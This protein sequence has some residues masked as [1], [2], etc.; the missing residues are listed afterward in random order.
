MY[1]FLLYLHFFFFCSNCNTAVVVFHRPVNN[2][3]LS[4]GKHFFNFKMSKIHQPKIEQGYL[5]LLFF[6][7]VQKRIYKFYFFGEIS[8]HFLQVSFDYNH[9][10]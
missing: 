1:I 2:I 5:L 8:K 10:T 3:M 4:F 7:N 9:T 6:T